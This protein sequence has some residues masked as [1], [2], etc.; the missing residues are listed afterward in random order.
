MLQK[1]WFSPILHFLW[2]FDRQAWSLTL[3]LGICCLLI[4]SPVLPS[5]LCQCSQVHGHAISW[6][7]LKITLLP[8]TWPNYLIYA[9]MQPMKNWGSKA[10]MLAQG[11]NN[12]KEK[13]E[14][15]QHLFTPI[16]LHK[17]ML[18]HMSEELFW[19]SHITPRAKRCKWEHAFYVC[20]MWL[21]ASRG[22]WCHNHCG[23]EHTRVRWGISW[24]QAVLWQLL[25]YMLLQG[26]AS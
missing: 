18:L 25:L 26:N 24:C 3:F 9:N 6:L 15:V 5:Y 23:Q 12:Q 17:E 22:S 2:V 21:C 13:G 1:I 10:E 16:S 8:V 20:I 11:R 19:C 4:P 14:E 7:R